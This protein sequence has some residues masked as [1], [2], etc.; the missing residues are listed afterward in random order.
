MNSIELKYGIMYSENRLYPKLCCR[1]HWLSKEEF[2]ATD[3]Q[4]RILRRHSYTY[5]C[6]GVC[7]PQGMNQITYFD[8]MIIIY[9]VVGVTC[10]CIHRRYGY[11]T[12]GCCECVHVTTVINWIAKIMAYM[13]NTTYKLNISMLLASRRG[14]TRQK[15]CRVHFPTLS[16]DLT[17]SVITI[18]QFV[19]FKGSRKEKPCENKIEKRTSRL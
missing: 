5:T 17:L 7:L 18:E 4:L 6:S 12:N 13:I 1:D 16:F 14:L 11:Y 9:P 10:K 15:I 8:H 19:I 2:N 3:L